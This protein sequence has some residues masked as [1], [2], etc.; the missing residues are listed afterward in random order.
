MQGPEI[1]LADFIADTG[2]VPLGERDLR[3]PDRRK[4]VLAG[5]I[6]L[7]AIGIVTLGLLP[8]APAFALGVLASMLM[9]TVPPRK[10]YAAIDWPVIVPLATLI[11]VAGAMQSTGAADLLARFLVCQSA[12]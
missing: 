11:P 3:L 7:A 5:A 6:M 4:A 9:R 12:R 2:C 10:V 1:A 8:A